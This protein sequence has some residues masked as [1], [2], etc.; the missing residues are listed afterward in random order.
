MSK[1]P[2]CNM[3]VDKKLQN[4]LQKLM[5]TKYFFALLHANNN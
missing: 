2:G 5:E 1:D 4:R 3:N